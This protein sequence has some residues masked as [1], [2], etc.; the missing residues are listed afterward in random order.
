[1]STKGASGKGGASL[2]SGTDS[3]GGSVKISGVTS[4]GLCSA[5]G[6]TAGLPSTPG[7]REGDGGRGE[8]RAGKV[9]RGSKQQPRIKTRKQNKSVVYWLVGVC[10]TKS[11]KSWTGSEKEDSFTQRG[12]WFG[13]FGAWKTHGGNALDKEKK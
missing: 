10:R 6:S 9:G 8:G 7:R 12:S 1:M 4:F 13:L 5:F 3:S 11:F 2:R